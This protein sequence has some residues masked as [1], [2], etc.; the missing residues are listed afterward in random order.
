[1]RS[2]SDHTTWSWPNSEN[3]AAGRASPGTM[4]SETGSPANRRRFGSK[5]AANS[6]PPL[7]YSRC[8]PAMRGKIAPRTNVVETHMSRLRAKIDRDFEPGL[9]HTIRGA[10]YCLRAPA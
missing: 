4:N 5:G 3:S 8:L 10:G 2:P 6:V 1:M 7:A 9:I